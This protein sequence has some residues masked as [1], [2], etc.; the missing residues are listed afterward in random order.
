MILHI[1]KKFYFKFNS[2]IVQENPKH[3]IKAVFAS[4][5]EEKCNSIKNNIESSLLLNSISSNTSNSN[6]SSI[7]NQSIDIISL[8]INKENKDDAK[9]ILDIHKKERLD[10]LAIIHK[11]ELRTF[12]IGKNGYYNIIVNS[13]Y[14]ELS[15]K[16]VTKYT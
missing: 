3:L 13:T 16:K 7:N 1:K 12:L 10:C 8:K 5:K 4:F 6:S 9:A 2:I 15:K 11:V 14:K